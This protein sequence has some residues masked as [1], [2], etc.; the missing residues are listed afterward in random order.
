MGLIIKNHSRNRWNDVNL[1]IAIVD[2]LALQ[3]LQIVVN[4]M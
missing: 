2:D 1:A 3:E 4:L